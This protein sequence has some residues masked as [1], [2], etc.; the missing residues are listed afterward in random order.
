MMSGTHERVAKLSITYGKGAGLPNGHG[1][2]RGRSI[3]EGVGPQ[4]QRQRNLFNRDDA[5]TDAAAYIGIVIVAV[6]YTKTRG[7]GGYLAQ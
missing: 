5:A 4:R 3:A 6:A 1:L 2:A 7:I